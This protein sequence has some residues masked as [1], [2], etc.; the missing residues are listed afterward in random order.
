MLLQTPVADVAAAMGAA[1]D[2]RKQIVPLPQG[3]VFW[4]HGRALLA[5]QLMCILSAVEGAICLKHP[6]KRMLQR[7]T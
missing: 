5:E 4:A 6:G 1:H 3:V 2:G 7:L